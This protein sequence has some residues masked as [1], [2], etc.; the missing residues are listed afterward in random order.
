MLPYTAEVLFALY[1]RYLGELWPASITLM[2]LTAAVLFLAW[3]AE[4]LAGRLA[5]GLLALGWLWVGAVF[6]LHYFA[7]INFAAP[8]YA[9]LF[10]LQ[11]LLLVWYGPLRGRLVMRLRSDGPGW[12]GSLVVLFAAL[13]YPLLDLLSGHPLDWP[14]LVG[15]A[16]GPTALFTLGMLLHSVGPTP[17]PLLAVPVIWSLVAAYSGWV[18]GLAADLAA[19]PLAIIALGTAWR[20]DR[21][22]RRSRRPGG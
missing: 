22:H 18:L 16:A 19:L 4:P 10:V 15:L 2:L 1:A 8:L 5:G 9:G 7:T 13:G 11:G 14:R 20:N 6:H 21:R 3:R 17:L 12:F